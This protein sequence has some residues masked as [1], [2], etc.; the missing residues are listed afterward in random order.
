MYFFK[1]LVLLF[2]GL[3]TSNQ[4]SAQEEDKQYLSLSFHEIDSIMMPKFNSSKYMDGVSLTYDILPKQTTRTNTPKDSIQ[5]KI[6]AWRSFFYDYLANYNE[7]IHSLEEAIKI[8]ETTLGKEHSYYAQLLINLA[9][10]HQ[11]IGNFNQALSLYLQAKD[12]QEKVFGSDHPDFATSLNNLAILYQK[13]GDFDKALS[14]L[15]QA[16]DI[17]EKVFGSDHPD[18]AHSLNNLSSLH[19]KMGN[20]D[21]ALPLLV[22]TKDI[23]QKSIG[24]DHPDFALSLKNLAVLY[25]NMGNFDKAL[26]LYLQANDIYEKVFG[27]DHPN[28]AHSLSSLA[29]LHSTMGNF[30]KALPLYLQVN[31]IY[32]KVFGND[33]PDFAK[34]LNSL[35]ILHSNMGNVD[36]ALPLYLQAKEIRKKVFG[37]E[38]IDFAASLN[39]LANTHTKMGNFDQALPLYLQAKDIEEKVLGIEHPSFAQS[40]HNLAILHQKMEN[41]DKALPLLLEAKDIYERTFGIEHSDFAQALNNLAGLHTEMGNFDKAW[42]Y[43]LQAISNLSSTPISSDLNNKYLNSLLQASYRSNLHLEKMNATLRITYDLLNKDSSI[44]NKTKIQILLADLAIELLTKLQKRLSN[45]KDKLRLLAQSNSWVQK[46]LKH[47]NPIKHSSKAFKLADQN[48]SVLL[49]QA[50]KSEAAYQLGNLPDSLVWRDKKIL[51]K[52]SQLQAKLVEKRPKLEI[53]SLRDELNHVNQDIDDFVRMIKKEYPRYHHLKYQQVTTKLTDIQ[54]L[55]EDN[56]ALLEYVISDS[57]VHIFFV[58]KTQ[59]QWVKSLVPKKELKQRIKALHH[60]LSDYNII[61]RN[62]KLAYGEYTVQAHW[63]YLNL[64]AP[65]LKDKKDIQNLILITDGELG[66]LPFETF[67]V[68]QA[69]QQITDYQQLHY[70]MN[71]YNISYNYSATL[72]QENI[73]APAPT[74]NGQVLA[75]AANYDIKL[76]SSMLDIR[77]PTDQ[78]VR[79]TLKHLPAAHK[80]V[81]TLQEKYQG[82]FAFDTLASEKMV[83]E[84]APNYAIL[85][86]ATHGI[87]DNKK[88][89]LSSLAFSE[90]NDSIESNFWQ[91]HEI[92]KIQLNA[93]LVVLSACETGYGKFEKGN[94]IASLARAFMY[95][96]ASALIVS[97]W[98]VNDYATSEIMKNLYDNLANG[99]KKDEALRQAKLQYIK[100]TEGILAHPAFWSPFIQMGNTESVS[101]RKKGDVTPWIMAGLIALFLLGGLFLMSRHKKELA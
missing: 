71:D 24:S 9:S 29:I 34:A 82:F 33:H 21:K 5:G 43:L 89:I 81:E 52:Q 23:F 19:Q 14:L 93:N 35:A 50:T 46:S 45:E 25:F 2:F 51:K 18:F 11:T 12:I 1:F 77:L 78:W 73:K 27:N 60:A 84:K 39:N 68:K 97:L 74:N 92:S 98:Q 90:D 88:P 53:D 83:K 76:D 91:A 58:D 47:F 41:F 69:P 48:K 20:F 4:I 37:K 96:G 56:T 72:W 79:K 7:A 100:S 99:M 86:F 65:I 70:L 26:P 57:V 36:K 95:A 22:Q 15:V 6:L 64:V 75:L 62:N 13:M 44:T 30:D 16:K 42:E 80:E 3:L 32:E 10:L 55:L 61:T 87:L 31:D 54:M 38:H 59:V 28:F 101:I 8:I 17:R 67:L 94:G 63:F 49:L 66:H 40:L 85:H